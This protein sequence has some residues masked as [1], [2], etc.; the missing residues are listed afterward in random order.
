MMAEKAVAFLFAMT[1]IASC[2]LAV[3]MSAEAQK[4]HSE[5]LML[6][7][8]NEAEVEEVSRGV[9]VN[10][11]MR[12]LRVAYL[13]EKI[14]CLSPGELKEIARYY[15]HYPRQIADS[16]GRIVTI[17]RPVE[18]I[19]VLNG[20]VAEAIRVL[21]AVDRIVGITENVRDASVF[22]PE[23]SSEKESVGSWY[24][25]DIEKTLTLDPDA[26]FAY[27]EWP[28]SE[29]LED[30]LPPTIAV[31]RLDFF[32][33]ETLRTEMQQ[34]GYVLDENASEYIQWH[35]KYIDEIK[36]KVSGIAEDEKPLVFLDNSGEESTKERK[37]YTRESGG[38]STLCELACG[39]NIAAELEGAY[40]EVELE[41]ILKHNPDV[42]VGLSNK[43]GYDT[44][45]G[46]VVEA[47][48][49]RLIGLSGLGNVTAVEDERVYIID[50]SVPF[51]PEYPIGLAYVAKW[52]YPTEFAEF[53]PQAMHQEYV[54]TF[55]GI[56]FDVTEH[57]V[58]VYPAVE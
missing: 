48:Y 56:D 23:L 44:D 7:G 10:E 39:K 15:P 27:V 4:Q 26:V 49:E 9:L 33:P 57:G 43:G 45:D 11:L 47:E 36:D 21:G 29:K 20:D 2:L 1:V 17:Y 31:I 41:W 30:K 8:V 52:L 14:E 19:V 35:D 40:P 13:D 5:P 53:E 55:C 38:I 54:D 16:A 24:S 51:A 37:T 6:F 22:F 25:P 3:V 58:F 42:I 18:R 12:Y 50:S 34:L 46:S 28:D 32:K